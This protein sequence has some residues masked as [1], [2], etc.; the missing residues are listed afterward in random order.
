MTTYYVMMMAIFGAF[1]QQILAG[2]FP[3]LVQSIKETPKIHTDPRLISAGLNQEKVFETP[4]EYTG[5]TV[6]G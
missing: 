3:E 5:A 6:Q 2:R 4:C 1:D